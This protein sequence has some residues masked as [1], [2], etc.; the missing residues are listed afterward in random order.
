MSTRFALQAF[1]KDFTGAFS[2]ALSCCP[3]ADLGWA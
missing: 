3:L 1:Q 2:K